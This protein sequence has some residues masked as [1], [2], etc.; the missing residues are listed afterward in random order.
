MLIKTLAITAFLVIIASLGNAL[1]NLARSND[2]EH[3]RKTV[4]ALT[5]RISLSL[6]LMIGL[7]VAHSLGL[8]DATGIGARIE[9]IHM[10]QS[11]SQ[12]DTKPQ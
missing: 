6:L 7:I 4:R 5:I 8:F 12:S 10:Q 11:P 2:P 9:A 1:F 3:S